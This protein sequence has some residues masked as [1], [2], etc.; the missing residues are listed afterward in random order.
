MLAAVDLLRLNPKRMVS[1]VST[2]LMTIV[3]RDLLACRRQLETCADDY[4]I[5]VGTKWSAQVGRLAKKP[6]KMPLAPFVAL[7]FARLTN[8]LN[9]LELYLV[10]LFGWFD[11]HRFTRSWICGCRLD[12]N[13]DDS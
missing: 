12:I 5:A 1:V 9:G 7:A 2:V 6:S 11:M 3:N 13:L 8:N 4:A 10:L